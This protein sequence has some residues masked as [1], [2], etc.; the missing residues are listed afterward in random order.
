MWLSEVAVVIEY[1]VDFNCGTPPRSDTSLGSNARAGR[2]YS[3]GNVGR[4][5]VSYVTETEL[6]LDAWLK[7][8]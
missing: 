8:F 3:Y 5:H 6:R 1:F 7:I 4:G 2:S